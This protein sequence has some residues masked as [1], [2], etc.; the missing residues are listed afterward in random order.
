ML[1]EVIKEIVDDV[2]ASEDI[3]E[4]ISGVK[5]GDVVVSV[6]SKNT[7]SVMIGGTVLHYSYSTLVG[8]TQNFETLVAENV[9]GTTTGK[10]LNTID[11][12]TKEAKANRVPQKDLMKIKL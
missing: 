10:F 3:K 5:A 4:G 9:W 7:S 6:L 1:E 11:G 8:V 12:G 2:L